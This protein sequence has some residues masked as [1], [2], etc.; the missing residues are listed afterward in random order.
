MQDR[1]NEQALHNETQRLIDQAAQ[2]NAASEKVLA[3]ANLPA[4]AEAVAPVVV[5][6]S[7]QHIIRI[8][9]LLLL[10]SPHD[11]YVQFMQQDPNKIAQDLLGVKPELSLEYWL[12]LYN[13]HPNFME[14]IW[15]N[16]TLWQAAR[17]Q[18]I[19]LLCTSKNLSESRFTFIN[20]MLHRGSYSIVPQGATPPPHIERVKVLVFN[21]A[22]LLSLPEIKLRF[23]ELLLE[24]ALPEPTEFLKAAYDN[25][26]LLDCEDANMMRLAE[27]DF[28]KNHPVVAVDVK[29]ITAHREKLFGKQ[30]VHINK[31]ETLGHIDCLASVHTTFDLITGNNINEINTP[32]ITIASQYP[33]IAVKLLERSH[34]TH[35]LTL[36][37]INKLA[38]LHFHFAVNVILLIQQGKQ[39]PSISSEIYIYHLAHQNVQEI[40]SNLPPSIKNWAELP[41]AQR[42]CV[43]R[44]IAEGLKGN[45]DLLFK[46]TMLFSTEDYFTQ[47]M[48]NE[49]L[50]NAYALGHRQA[51]MCLAENYLQGR[52]TFP[53][54]AQAILI[55]QD[56]LAHEPALLTAEAVDCLV[57]HY[58]QTAYEAYEEFTAIRGQMVDLARMMDKPK[59]PAELITSL[60]TSFNAAHICF[61]H[62]KTDTQEQ[63][64]QLEKTAQAKADLV[65]AHFEPII[66]LPLQ[67]RPDLCKHLGW[68]TAHMMM[69]RVLIEQKD[70]INDKSVWTK[71]VASSLECAW[72]YDTLPGAD[73]DLITLITRIKAMK[74]KDITAAVNTLKFEKHL[75]EPPV[76]PLQKTL[77]DKPAVDEPKLRR[78]SS[79][80]NLM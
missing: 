54:G 48:L 14:A 58:F 66:S 69:L 77:E 26:L 3:N 52:G 28:R 7:P 51:G 24:L 41:E 61:F 20:D 56:I 64:I 18:I 60:K 27:R 13:T 45:I 71:A 57:Q 40:L 73:P 59:P 38:T 70:M 5:A 47:S 16:A 39:P 35:F 80:P 12:Y 68:Q 6:N 37:V 4:Q 34:F 50:L 10:R 76:N 42:W 9:R 53:A 46:V 62:H 75:A 23:I 65:I 32:M 79:V 43:A 17:Q 11:A 55:Y 31:W 63:L 44:L 21:K 78:S 49:L 33:S 30:L 74:G 67:N 8:K 29:K 72:D 22:F 1:F 19:L 2:D 36:A 15:S 25:Q